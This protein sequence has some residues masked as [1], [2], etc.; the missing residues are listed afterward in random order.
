MCLTLLSRYVV[1]I[2]LTITQFG[3]CSVYFVFIGNSLH[4]V[5]HTPS[6][7][8]RSP[9]HPHPH[10]LSP[11][12]YQVFEDAFNISIRVQ[13]WI[14]IVLPL[15]IVCCWIR[16]L[17]TLT[18]FSLIANMC[19]IFSLVVILYEIIY[20][21]TS[22][23]PD[24]EASIREEPLAIATA[25]TFPLYFGTVVYAFEGIGMVRV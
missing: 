24:E 3:F 22:E 6:C 17:D 2:F 7:T 14:V 4:N 20:E 18:P 23:N 8:T 19:I 5:S 11:L 16:D 1:N 21:L 25:A 10:P 15:I 9:T 13:V 12:S